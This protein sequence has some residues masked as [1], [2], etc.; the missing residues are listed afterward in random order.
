MTE[1][2][3]EQAV[4]SAAIDVNG[5]K[6]AADSDDTPASKSAGRAQ[7]SFPRRTIQ[8]ALRVPMAIRTNNGGEPFAPGEVA[9][10]INVGGKTSN[11][12][13]LTTASR[14]YG[15]TT[16][17]RDSAEI[18]LTQLGRQAVYPGSDTEAA[19]ARLQAFLNVSAFKGVV[20][21]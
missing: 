2:T 18:A 19:D 17:T 11:F 5:D 10:A 12:F 9:K 3:P 4:N 1:R 7:Y 15:F 21:H 13:Y 8:D 20:E 14:D 6:P 16:G